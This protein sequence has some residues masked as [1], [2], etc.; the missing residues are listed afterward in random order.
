MKKY[1]NVGI[2]V[3][4]IGSFLI[5][6]VAASSPHDDRQES[7]KRYVLSF[8]RVVDGYPVN[9]SGTF[10]GIAIAFPHRGIAMKL[11]VGSF[12]FDING[13]IRVNPFHREIT[14]SH[15]VVRGFVGDFYQGGNLYGG[16]LAGFAF[17]VTA[18]PLPIRGMVR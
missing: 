4:L 1:V 12:S 5:V 7:G 2:L 16:S 18:D 10:H 15:V 9:C 13:T 8:I 3:L 11:G 6:S 17:Q 14:N